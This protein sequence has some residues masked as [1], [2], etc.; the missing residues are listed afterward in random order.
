MEQDAPRMTG[1]TLKVLV[2][3][4]E[5][6][7]DEL[8]GADVAKGAKLA[9]GTLY[10]ILLRLEKAGWLESRWETEHP[11]E[12]G[13]PRRRYYRVTGLGARQARAAI[14]EVRTTVGKLSW[15]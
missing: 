14:A 8:S 6:P 3:L 7:R 4:L 10:P 5:S 15:A 13:R 12:M 2:A 9:S 11:Q 1:P